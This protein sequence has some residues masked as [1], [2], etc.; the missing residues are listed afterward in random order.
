MPRTSLTIDQILS[1]LAQAPPRIAASTDGLAPAQLQT[2]PHQD[3]WS[4]NDV[5]AHVR[6]C[7]DVWGSCIKAMLAQDRPTLRAVNPRSWIKKTDYRD[8]DFHTSLRSFTTQPTDLLTVLEPL[9]LEAWSRAATV[10]AQATCSSER[11]CSTPNG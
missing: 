4:A 3:S 7:A 11:C 6:A 1:V 5:L 8:L 2:V 10:T 9:P